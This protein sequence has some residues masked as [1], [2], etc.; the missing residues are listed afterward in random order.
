MRKQSHE[1]FKNHTFMCTLPSENENDPNQQKKKNAL[2]K[3][4][5]TQPGSNAP[6]IIT[7]YPP[8]STPAPHS[9]HP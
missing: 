4:I 2:R 5:H 7:S 8:A 1:V 9:Y 6:S 3:H